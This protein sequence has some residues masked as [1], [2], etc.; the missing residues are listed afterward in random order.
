M[1]YRRLFIFVST[2]ASLV[3]LA[4]AVSSGNGLDITLSA[5]S[6]LDTTRLFYPVGDFDLVSPPYSEVY[7]AA[8]RGRSHVL[9]VIYAVISG[10]SGAGNHWSLI[11]SDYDG[12]LIDTLPKPGNFAGN[13]YN[14][15]T[16]LSS[17]SLFYVFFRDNTRAT[18]YRIREDLTFVDDSPIIVG[19][20]D[21]AEVS[22]HVEGHTLWT[23]STFDYDSVCV[24]VFDFD[25]LAPIV[26]N[27]KIGHRQLWSSVASDKLYMCTAPWDSAYFGA[28]YIDKSGTVTRLQNIKMD[29][30]VK[31]NISC[32]S[33][34]P[35]GAD[36]ALFF[37]FD[38]DSLGRDQFRYFYLSGSNLTNETEVC[39]IP[40]SLPLAA[41]VGGPYAYQMSGDTL[42][43]ISTNLSV[44]EE[45]VDYLV[46]ALENGTL[47]QK[48][49][50]DYTIV[51]TA[52]QFLTYTFSEGVGSYYLIYQ[53]G[54]H[55]MRLPF[56]TPF[57]ETSHKQLFFNSGHLRRPSI[58]HNVDEVLVV[59]EWQDTSAVCLK[60]SLL[61][62]LDR[63]TVYAD[64]R[65]LTDGC[66]RLRPQLHRAAGKELLV[67]LEG[68][69][70]LSTPSS[71]A[72]S[73]AEYYYYHKAT[74]FSGYLPKTTDMIDEAVS[75]PPT[76]LLNRHS[77]CRTIGDTAY[78][79]VAKNDLY[80][81]GRI[82]VNTEAL[83]G[84]LIDGNERGELGT[85]LVNNDTLLW[86]SGFDYCTEWEWFQC[87][88]Y[89]WGYNG[90]AIRN[91]Q[92]I[93]KGTY[94]TPPYSV[95]YYEFPWLS[96]L[97]SF[98]IMDGYG[99]RDL[100][101]LTEF[102]ELRE[103]DFESKELVLFKDLSCLGCEAAIYPT[104]YGNVVVRYYASS[105]NIGVTV[106]DYWWNN[107]ITTTTLTLE[108]QPI[109]FSEFVY[110][111]DDRKVVFAYSA[112]VP[113]P[114]AAVRT[115]VRSIDFDYP[116]TAEEIQAELP[117]QFRL[118]QNYP[119]PF[120]PS[121]VIEYSLPKSCHTKI[122]V[123]NI[124]GQKVTTLVDELKPAGNHSVEW[125]GTNQSGQPAASGIYFY[126]MEAGDYVGSKK[127]LLL[128]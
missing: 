56:E 8:S 72:S 76:P 47:L 125:N 19:E 44:S 40:L 69:Y 80:R 126:K 102:G 94:H 33:G 111:P 106:Y 66:R 85:L 52:Y 9:T 35:C 91:G 32:F 25:L 112:Y 24:S 48:N 38:E 46:F 114:Y 36:S 20:S 39:E 59:S 108:D 88:Y 101:F 83:I 27:V 127:M 84:G 42:V 4:P 123:Y 119:N 107:V 7:G 109:E 53:K 61:K 122:G 3:V 29:G 113:E 124:L 89:F 60:A 5:P 73:I 62:D 115:F 22:Y 67:W 64:R 96:D 31:N 92:I 99:V 14:F 21:D 6:I 17:D 120:N 13:W 104:V 116:T 37:F 28:F 121:C 70:A 26:E 50:V 79:G 78:V 117:A 1:S 105:R 98:V 57:A 49:W 71:S 58:T 10:G 45:F 30:F 103:I 90:I 128:K 55:V 41:G 11:R 2:A 93:D 95:E 65:L 15:E 75:L 23:I 118:S 68:P 87:I 100:P 12:N 63:L 34:L 74:L 81:I 16:V 18:C 82:N 86:L 97:R 51:P 110:L 54:V 77:V 43:L